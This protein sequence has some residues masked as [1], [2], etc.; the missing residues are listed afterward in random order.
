M[1]ESANYIDWD[2]DKVKITKEIMGG[3]VMPKYEK[4]NYRENDSLS[5]IIL[6]DIYNA[7]YKDKDVAKEPE[8]AKETEVVKEPENAKET[9]VAK[10]LCQRL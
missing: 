10:E 5:D 9:K 6:D 1:N 4:T 3:Y 7:F 8:N 2:W